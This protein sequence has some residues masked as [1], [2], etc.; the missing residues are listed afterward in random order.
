M[1][2]TLQ[3]TTAK[4]T[5]TSR[6]VV[7]GA[8]LGLVPSLSIS[9]LHAVGDGGF[10]WELVPGDIV[11]AIIYASPYLVALYAS[12][13]TNPRSQVPLYLATTLL[14]LVA[15]F[16]TFSG[17][18]LFLLPVTIVL[19]VAAVT[20]CRAS[21]ASMIRKTVLSLE[22]LVVA[23][24]IVEAFFTLYLNEDDRCWNLGYSQTDV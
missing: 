18:T 17:V 21:D 23:M 14:S 1:A 7:T 20:A 16:S 13:L 6:F 19:A 11:F 4:T 10:E 2:A 9:V 24:F 5:P 22:S 15:S 12:T 8:L 3:T